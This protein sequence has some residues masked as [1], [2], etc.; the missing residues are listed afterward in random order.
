MKRIRLGVLGLMVGCLFILAIAIK[1]ILYKGASPVELV[2]GGAFE[3]R[4]SQALATSSSVPQEGRDYAFSNTKSFSSD[5]DWVV[6]LIT[7]TS[8]SQIT[9][10]WVVLKKASGAYELVLGPGSALPATSA[11]NL[12]IVVQQYLNQRGVLYGSTD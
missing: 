9:Q 2:A 5:G 3:G 12:P 1:P 8:G 7:P 11:I 4:V 6:S 10:G